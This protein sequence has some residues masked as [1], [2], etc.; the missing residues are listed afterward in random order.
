MTR[1]I[2]KL[3]RLKKLI[4]FG[5]IVLSLFWAMSA[6][7]GTTL[8]ISQT[9]DFQDV[10]FSSEKIESGVGV[11]MAKGDFNNDGIDDFAIGAIR[12]EAP[13]ITGEV[14]MVSV[15]FGRSDLNS[16]PLN[17]AIGK[18]SDG[19]ED[20]RLFGNVNGNHVGSMIV[21]GD[22]NN[23][24]YDDLIIAAQGSSNEDTAKVFI[25][26]GNN[27]S[28]DKALDISADVTLDRDFIHIGALAAGDINGDGI[29]DLAISDI[30]TNDVNSPP[31]KTGHSPSGGVYIIFGKTIG[32][33]SSI[34]LQNEADVTISRNNGN[35][36]LQV[37]SLAIGDV[38][39]DQQ[40]DLVMGTPEEDGYNPYAGDV[41]EGG[42]VYIIFG[43]TTNFPSS[44]NVDID[45]EKDVTIRGQQADDKI[46]GDLEV[47]DT[48]YGDKSLAVGDI[49][50]D[51]IGDI[52]IGAPLSMVGN[53]GS[54]GIGKVEIVF[55]S[56][57]WIG[58]TTIDLFEDYNMRLKF[59]GGAQRI[60]TWTGFSVDVEDVNGDGQ[61][62]IAVSSPHAPA[63]DYNGYMHVIYGGSNLGIGKKD[64][65]IDL[66]SDLLITTESDPDRYGVGHLGR[67][68][69]IGNFDDS[70]G[71]DII[72]GAPSGKGING[73]TDG[74]WAVVLWDVTAC[75][76]G[77]GNVNG[78]DGTDL[79]D[80]ILALQVAAGAN[81]VDGIRPDYQ[82]A[83]V[84]CDGKIGMVEAVYILQKAAGL[85]N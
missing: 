34:D 74:G 28:G 21:S 68:F 79:T 51:N 64:Y 77:D 10:V 39:N 82:A 56:D 69:V 36:V 29:D 43:G 72:M 47:T 19:Q 30:L 71:P 20:A 76:P 12:E 40:S 80:L 62:D 37:A 38:N 18:V 14:G 35:N 5:Y 3:K 66:E 27:I 4:I 1:G 84:N 22:L 63:D 16:L 78:A 15:F 61:K 55:G 48:H 11:S 46:G 70:S 17:V 83:D 42:R 6:F 50:G 60:G 44:G 7:A 25:V 9:S 57:S 24:G 52:L 65:E 31:V 32:W 33:P 81:P 67:S 58:G 53:V 73:V 49:N 41:S 13:F 75:T 2:D 45:T 59:S 85:R 8:V 23:D 26:F 54:T